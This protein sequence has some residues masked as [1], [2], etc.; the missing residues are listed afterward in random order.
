[1]F[2]NKHEKAKRQVRSVSTKQLVVGKNCKYKS[3]SSWKDNIGKIIDIF[4]LRKLVIWMSKKY[5]TARVSQT[6]RRRKRN[7]YKSVNPGQKTADFDLH[8]HLDD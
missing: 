7:K 2:M 6:R 4:V 5:T 1:M 8:L 3:Y